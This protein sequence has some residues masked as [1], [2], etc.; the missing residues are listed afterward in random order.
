MLFK[1]IFFRQTALV[2][3]FSIA[4]VGHDM[5]HKNVMKPFMKL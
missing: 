1:E 2:S 4:K 5:N 3:A